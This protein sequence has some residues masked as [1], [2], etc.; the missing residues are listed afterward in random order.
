[1]KRSRQPV[2][3]DSGTAARAFR[4]IIG[5]GVFAPPFDRGPFRML[6]DPFGDVGLRLHGALP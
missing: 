1:M 5:V 4:S 3:S 6:P 2:A